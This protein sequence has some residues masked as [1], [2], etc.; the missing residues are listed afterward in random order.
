VTNT[1]EQVATV[2]YSTPAESI[3]PLLPVPIA[4]ESVALAIRTA[5]GAAV[6]LTPIPGAPGRFQ[7]TLSIT[8]GE[9]VRLAGSVVGR[10]IEAYTTVPGPLIVRE[11]A[12]DTLRMSEGAGRVQVPYAWHAVGS[13][14]Y[15]VQVT[16]TESPIGGAR[17]LEDTS[18]VLIADL[19]L[20]PGRPETSL[21]TV[22]ALDSAAA[23]FFRPLS[24]TAPRPGNIAGAL[25]LFGSA[26]VLDPPKVVLW[27]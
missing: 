7:A 23:A 12:A 9:T 22:F 3:V 8:P 27:Q 26:S 2:L 21:F 16:S 10:S 17:I 18:G 11:P 6:A 19:D 15:L 4:P 5:A 20:H 1:S 24:A 25:G 13:T 14:A